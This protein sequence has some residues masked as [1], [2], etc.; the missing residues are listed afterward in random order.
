MSSR[1]FTLQ[2]QWAYKL[3]S[4]PFSAGSVD[5]YF[6]PVFSR[7]TLSQPLRQQMHDHHE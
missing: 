6:A 1:D 7:H 2:Y 3:G 4:I 5:L